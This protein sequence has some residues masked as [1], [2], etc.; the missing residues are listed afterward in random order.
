M[1]TKWTIAVDAMGGDNAPKSVIE[2]LNIVYNVLIE[3]NISLLLFGDYKV[4]APYLLKYPNINNISTVVQ[5]DEVVQGDDKPSKIIRRGRNTS[6]WKAIEAVRNKEADAVISGG[7]TGCLM[8]LA[9]ILISMIGGIKRPAITTFIPT[10]SGG[11]AMLDLGANTECDENNILDFAIMGS[12]YVKTLLEKENST[13]GILNIGTEA[14][15]GLE[16]LTKAENIFANLSEKLPFKYNGFIEGNDILEGKVDVIVTDGFSGNIA[17]KSIEGTARFIKTSLK[18]IFKSSLLSM[19][20]YILLYKS[21]KKLK[22]KIDP[23]K[24]NGAVLLGLNGI[25]V[26]SHGGADAIG[27]SNAVTYTIKL[28]TNN[29]IPEIGRI[30]NLI[31]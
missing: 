24:Y 28:L 2:G 13:V 11:S 26:K 9:K 19:L 23:S 29:F 8:G 30:T 25:V 16:Y 1:D 18:N 22:T 17:L 6:M 4:L 7:N 12:V 31:K 10:K 3:N 27:F 21:F 20:G 5:C 15:K 14:G